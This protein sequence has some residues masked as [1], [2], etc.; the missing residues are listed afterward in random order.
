MDSSSPF[1]VN[2]HGEILRF[3]NANAFGQLLSINEGR[4]ASSYLPWHYGSEAG[5]LLGHLARNNPQ[6]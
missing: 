3:I 5:K 4:I 6:L 2:D 1:T